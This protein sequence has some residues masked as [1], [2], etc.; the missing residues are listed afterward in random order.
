M[1]ITDQ[2]DIAGDNAVHA[3][4]ASGEAR[5][6]ILTAVAGPARFGSIA[7]VGA[8]RGVDLP[9]G[10]PVTIRA[11]EA[12]RT[13]KFNLAQVAC[14]VPSGTTLTITTGI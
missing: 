7:T 11:S 1:V 12:D 13:D 4:A 6:L 9:T 10:I 2:P 5:V 8:A 3:I 14:Y